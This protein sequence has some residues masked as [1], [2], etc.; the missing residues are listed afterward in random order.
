MFCLMNGTHITIGFIIDC[1]LY[2]VEKH[3]QDQMKL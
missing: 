2:F 3:R 1:P